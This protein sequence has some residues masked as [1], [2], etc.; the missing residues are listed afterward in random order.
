[1]QITYYIED[2]YVGNRP[3]YVTVPDSELEEC[4]TEEQKITL[5]EQLIEEHFNEN[6]TWRWDRKIK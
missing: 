1:M 2:G 3:K 6:V 4:E 5:I